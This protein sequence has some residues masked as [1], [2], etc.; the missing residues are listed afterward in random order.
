MKLDDRQRALVT[1]ILLGVGIFAIGVASAI[2]FSTTESP[3]V[4]PPDVW[5]YALIGLQTL[6]L[7]W[8]RRIPVTVLTLTIAGFMVDR[9]L[10]YPP[11]LAAGGMAFAIYTIGA[12]LE[13]K[14]SLL[15]GG[16]GIDVVLG[17]TLVGVF[18]YDVDPLSLVTSAAFLGL[19]LLVGRESYHRQQRM[20][21]LEARAI[22][23]EHEREQRAVEAVDNERRRIS[24]ELHDV[25]AHEITV[26]TLQSAGARR[27]LD[28]NKEKAAEAMESAEAAGHRALTEMRRLL[29]ML[30]TE[31]PRNMT[32]QPGLASL[33]A[34]VEQME[35]AGL[36]IELAIKGNPRPLPAGLDLNVYRIIQES[37]TNTVKHG[38]PN[39]RAR[40]SL[41]YDAGDLN[42]E[43][44]D[45]GRGA[46][47]WDQPGSGQ[48]IVGMRER[49][50]L[51]KGSLKAGPRAGGGY[52][53]AAR[54]PIPA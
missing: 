9:G 19:P 22:R 6:P 53:V 31:D 49:V 40:V 50:T 4:R 21:E 17:W 20:V 29:G 28:E 13:P 26:M 18:V 8:R 42:V 14:R 39:V 41:T 16:V 1:D 51:L 2:G 11:T 44:L 54:I 34:L 30:R 27:V 32:P 46:A 7:I 15:I 47:A 10:N 36:P 52:R 12:Q 5:A 33:E 24:R 23:A 48:G 37:L 45:D 43:V 25:V 3:D 38:G 35:L